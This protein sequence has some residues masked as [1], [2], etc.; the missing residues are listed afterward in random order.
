MWNNENSSVLL[1]GE[2]ILENSSHYPIKLEL[3]TPN[4]SATPPPSGIITPGEWS[5][6]VSGDIH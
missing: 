2:E 6:C 1:V 4:G 3:Y 5:I